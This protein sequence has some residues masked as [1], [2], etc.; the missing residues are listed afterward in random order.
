MEEELKT[1]SRCGESKPA[2][3]FTSRTKRCRK[4]R[5]DIWRENRIAAG[6]DPDLI[7]QTKK[8]IGRTLKR[9]G[10]EAPPSEWQLNLERARHARQHYAAALALQGG[11]CGICGA[12]K[13]RMLNG[14]PGALHRDH[15]EDLQ[16][17]RGVLCLHCNSGL[18]MF[19]DN[20]QFL[21]SAI[22]Y[23]KRYAAMNVESRIKWQKYKIYPTHGRLCE[24]CNQPETSL[25]DGEITRPCQDHD[26]ATGYLR[27]VLCRRCNV[28]ISKFGDDLELLS[29]AIKYLIQW[30]RPEGVSCSR[31]IEKTNPGRAPARAPVPS[32]LEPTGNPRGLPAFR[33]RRD[34]N[35]DPPEPT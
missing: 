20:T 3:S 4:C 35:T 2:R 8:N 17:L 7:R 6:E 24:I 26:H 1:C 9:L 22:A 5:D 11:G 10:V 15:D 30:G 31:R 12:E 13:S 23:L 21:A 29:N 34:A 19:Q 16:I 33:L 28:G 25:R 18:G 27:G 14:K 32:F